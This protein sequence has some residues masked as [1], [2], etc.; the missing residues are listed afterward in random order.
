MKKNFHPL[1][2]H[3][4]HCPPEPAYV[5]FMGICGT[6]MASLAGLL[7]G[8]GI[9]VYGSDQE[10]YPPMSTFLQSLSIP[11]FEGYREENLHP[12]PDLV[13][14]GN[15]I[16]RT[17][18]EVAA[19]A[20]M[21]IPYLS[22]PQAVAQFALRD[23]EVIVVAGT[24]GKTTT[25]SAMAWLLHEA[26]LEPGFL[27]GGIPI[28]FGKGFQ[29][30]EGPY[31]VIEGDEYDSAFFDKGPKFLHYNPSH[32]ILTNIEFDHAD[33]YRDLSH[34]MESFEALVPLV[35]SSGTL[36]ACRE[37]PNIQ[38]LL[39]RASGTVVSYGFG[40][41]AH[42]QITGHEFSSQGARFQVVYK[43]SSIAFTTRLSG[44]HNL[45]NLGAAISLSLT[46]GLPEEQV[47]K[48]IN[49]FKGV[50]RRQE[51]VGEK[52]DILVIDDFAHHPTE[53]RETI[54][55][56]RQRY[57]SRRLVAVFEPRSNSS[58]RNIFQEQYSRAFDQAHVVMVPSPARTDNIPPSE[59]FS[60][61]R[62]VQELLERGI[63]AHW[64]PTA[65]ELL[66]LLLNRVREGDV[67]LFM[68]NGGFD[69]LPRRFLAQLK[70]R[71]G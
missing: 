14:V 49:S 1:S 16:R 21:E 70:A 35:P 59:R 58:R 45:L 53:V 13:I 60:S 61:T 68:S 30:P 36:V 62:L 33:I 29:P 19:L 32:L 34:V 67:V 54:A 31:F 11:V 41:D 46:L 20:R 2:P 24:H 23:K 22:F 3:L 26:D 44:L 57:P 9:K 39:N 17:N 42:F 40:S 18:P 28:N 47:R 48:A 55:G 6:G 52:G 64:T 8:C 69:D 12:A 37:D 5:Y 38:K 43:S 63:D 27:I 51:L 25:V 50:R 56:I 4:N 15:V 7:K 65:S 66:W 71:Y 10:I